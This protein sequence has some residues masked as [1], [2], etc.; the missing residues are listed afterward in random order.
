MK[1]EIDMWYFRGNCFKNNSQQLSLQILVS[2]R[3]GCHSTHHK[4]TDDVAF[5]RYPR[6]QLSRPIFLLFLSGVN[7]HRL[8]VLDLFSKQGRFMKQAL[9]YLNLF[10]FK[11]NILNLTYTQS[12]VKA[13]GTS[14]L[15]IAS[16]LAFLKA[17]S[18]ATQLSPIGL[19]ALLPSGTETVL[20][21]HSSRHFSKRW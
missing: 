4:Q 16:S 15:L 13:G 20:T 2:V 19:V 5:D 17:A 14:P 6:R 11:L 7:I 1:N 3:N 21:A 9:F 8:P 12:Q 10:M 18:V